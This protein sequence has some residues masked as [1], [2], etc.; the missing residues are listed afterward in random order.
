MSWIKVKNMSNIS[1]INVVVFS[2]VW[3]IVEFVY[4]INNPLNEESYRTRCN[5]DWVL[6]NYCPNIVD[7][8]KNTD[9]DGGNFVFSYTNDIGQRVKSLST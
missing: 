5:Y 7:V 1:L 8:K 4:F 3:V 9:S 6:Y 2:F